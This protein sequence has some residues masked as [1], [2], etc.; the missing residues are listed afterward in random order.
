MLKLVLSGSADGRP[1][2]TVLT[3][4]GQCLRE[5]IDLE[6]GGIDLEREVEHVDAEQA[7]VDLKTAVLE[8]EQKQPCTQ[9]SHFTGIQTILDT[10]AAAE[11][12]HFVFKILYPDTW[13]FEKDRLQLEVGEAVAVYMEFCLIAASACS[14]SIQYILKWL[15]DLNPCLMI[16]VDVEA[17]VDASSFTA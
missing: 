4:Y 15:K 3:F 8:C 14:N 17:D 16:V 9:I 1:I 13:E 11:R 2:K 7:I 10:T 6:R 5:Q 12:I